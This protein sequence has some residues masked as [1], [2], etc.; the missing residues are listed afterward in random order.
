M[1]GTAPPFLLS[2]DQA[3]RLH[4]YIQA[5]RTY[6][7]TSLLP[8]T[9]RNTV[10]RVL[11]VLQSKLI[12]VLDRVIAPSYP[13]SL[14]LTREEAMTLKVAATELIALYSRQP[15]SAER[16]ARLSDLAALKLSLKHY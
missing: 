11:Q 14:L 12:E 13:L 7:L 2:R 5:Y 1:M 3:Q 8:S 4:T 9:E 15:E 6:A 10:L 16:I